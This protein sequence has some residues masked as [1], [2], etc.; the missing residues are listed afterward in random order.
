MIFRVELKVGIWAMTGSQTWASRY[1][2]EEHSCPEVGVTTVTIAKTETWHW[3]VGWHHGAEE[4]LVRLGIKA[5]MSR[6]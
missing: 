6:W 3:H 1:L 5:S 2:A 4:T